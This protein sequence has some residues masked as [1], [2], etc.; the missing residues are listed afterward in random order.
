[1]DL[2]GIPGRTDPLSRGPAVEL[3]ALSQADEAVRM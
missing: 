2:D 3:T 1:M